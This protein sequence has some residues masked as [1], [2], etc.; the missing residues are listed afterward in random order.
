MA[1]NCGRIVSAS[2]RRIRFKF[3]YTNLEA[4]SNG[5]T[6]QECRGSEH[7]VIITWSLSSGKQAIAFDQH[8]VYFDVGDSTQTKISHCWKDQLGHTL[9]VKVHAANVSTKANPDPDW[10]QYDILINGVSF[11]RMP[12]IF[13]IGIVAKDEAA[14]PPF[15]L[16]P[17]FAQRPASRQSPTQGSGQFRNNSNN[18]NSILPPEEPKKEEPKPIEVADLLSFDEMEAP[19]AAPA[20][21]A[22]PQLAQV[23]ANNAA[24]AF[25]QASAQTAPAPAFARAPVAP[26]PAQYQQNYTQPANPYSAPTNPFVTPQAADQGLANNVP[27]Q[28]TNHAA[29]PSAN[30][31]FAAPAPTMQTYNETNYTAPTPTSSYAPA[32]NPVT[33]PAPSM[34]LVTTDPAPTSYGNLVNFDDLFGTSTAPATKES[35]DSK[36]QETNVHKS[37]GQLQG[38][39]NMHNNEAKKPVMNPF[40][41]APT[42]Q[43]QAGVYNG[44]GNQPQYSNFS[45]QPY[46]QPGYG[47]Q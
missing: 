6:G 7:E 38:S 14:G 3:G 41:S 12:K 26:A 29:A 32:P 31:S 10:K 27:A 1:V 5:K 47:Y 4:L 42:H 25:V 15:K 33:P 39:A 45:Q 35:V 34:A 16:G 18:M 2:K 23:Q 20:V 22:P 43:Q 11:F 21:A 36:M 13:Q 28:T 40:N 8:E 30:P 24:P 44:Y 9:E 37:L 17:K 46:A 19:V